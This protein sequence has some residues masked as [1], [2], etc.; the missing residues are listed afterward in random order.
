[1]APSSETP[2]GVRLIVCQLRRPVRREFIAAP[3][4]A[5]KGQVA[6]HDLGPN[7]ARS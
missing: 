3:D 7:K 5:G 1:M 2:L 6:A 4:A